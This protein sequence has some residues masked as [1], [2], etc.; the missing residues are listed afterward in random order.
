MGLS[1][2]D[3]QRIDQHADMIGVSYYPLKENQVLD[4]TVLEQHLTDLFRVYPDKTIDLY[5][6]GYPSSTEINSRLEKQRQFVQETF[7]AWDR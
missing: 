6:Y 1:W 5:Q 2:H 7:R 3:L 4:P